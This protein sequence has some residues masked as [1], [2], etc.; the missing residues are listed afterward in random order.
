MDFLQVQ[1][2]VD[3]LNKISINLGSRFMRQIFE[4]IKINALCLMGFLILAG[5]YQI[6]FFFLTKETKF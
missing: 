5:R 3:Y 1:K 2:A 6:V 4:L